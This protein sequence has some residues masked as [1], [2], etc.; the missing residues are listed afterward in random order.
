MNLATIVE[1]HP[2]DALALISGD[3]TVTYGELRARAASCRVGLTQAGLEVGDRVAIVL[4]N[5]VDF[6]IAY[7]AVLGAGGVAVPLNPQSPA[8]E[9]AREVATVRPRLVVAGPPEADGPTRAPGVAAAGAL[10]VPVVDVPS[11]EAAGAGAGG[12]GSVD[13]ADAD[14]AVLLFT[15]GTAGFPKAAIL[16]H[17]SLRANIEQ[18]ELRVSLAAQADDIGILLLPCSHVFGLNAVLGIHLFI[19]AA[20]VI[21]G[22][23]DAAATLDLVREHRV[24]TMAAVPTVFGALAALQD[25]TSEHLS[26]VRLAISGAA[27]L[28][29]EVAQR[30]ES[31]FGIRL[32]Q[33]YGLTEASPA[34]AFT[35]PDGTD[36]GPSS[37]G[38]P[39]PGIEVRI[40]DPDGEEVVPG[41]PGELLVR[42]PNVFAGYFEDPGATANVIDRAGW[43]H[44]GD[45]AVMADDAT[46]T[47]VDRRKD[48]IIV[49][50]FN[51]YP[52]EVEQALAEH[53][54]VEAVAVVGV[55]DPTTSEAVQ[56]FVVPS[57]EALA[58]WAEGEAEPASPT[59]DELVQHCRR[60]L[61]RYKCPTRVRFVRE[62]PRGL[63]GELLRRALR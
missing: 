30:F 5:G 52:A 56:A 18:M 60:L 47:L 15:S 43:L 28:S 41:D 10:D 20:L 24:T 40:V 63:G 50:G 55:P 8:P 6:V 22:R 13:R 61:A 32:L 62:L 34:V 26:T 7:L 1:P 38:T 37:V 58:N 48:L 57:A 19:G 2:A 49:S 16:T 12:G 39:L 21:T 27:P 11:L 35:D 14:Q 23:F 33:G 51:V 42:G 3:A 17:G 36:H 54:G 29:A 25:A 45:V 4:P 44:T 31:R 53:P 59:A 9:L 46:I